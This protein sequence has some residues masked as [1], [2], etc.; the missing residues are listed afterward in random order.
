MGA[1]IVL[2]GE[3]QNIQRESGVVTF[4]IDTGPATRHPP[5]GLKLY[6][7]THYRIECAA[8]QWDRAHEDPNDRSALLIEGYLEAR[9]DA[10]TGRPY[11]AVAVTELQS[12]LT[13][14]KRRLKQLEQARDEARQV[15]T[16]ARDAQA[17]EPELKERAA[18]FIQANTAVDQ[19]LGRHPYLARE[20]RE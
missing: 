1:K 14:N 8:S 9:Q 2:R 16:L 10:A 5:P 13:H 6:G 19:F 7:R 12:T 3:A 15:F 11:I 20:A 18:A 17:S 4:T